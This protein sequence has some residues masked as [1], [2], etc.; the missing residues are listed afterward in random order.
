[1]RF[2]SGS[3]LSPESHPSLLLN[4]FIYLAKE[5]LSNVIS[6]D[7]KPRPKLPQTFVRTTTTKSPTKPTRKTTTPA[8][9]TKRPKT[10]ATKRPKTTKRPTL[11]EIFGNEGS[12][13][14]LRY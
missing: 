14:V 3:A 2:W 13:N 11:Q 6:N 8:A 10:K 1:M 12:N 5:D 9:A 4:D 7:L